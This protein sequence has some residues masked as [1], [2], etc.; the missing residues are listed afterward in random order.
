MN[1]RLL[2]IVAF[3]ALMEGNGGVVGKSPDYIQEKFERYVETDDPGAWHWGLDSTRISQLVG[4]QKVW[5]NKIN[6]DKQ[7][8]LELKNE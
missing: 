8:K 5:F 7:T 6:Q 3:C 4:Y 2:N 1:P